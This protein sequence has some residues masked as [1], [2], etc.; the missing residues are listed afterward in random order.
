M[1][2]IIFFELLDSLIA[3]VAHILYLSTLFTDIN[4]LK[5]FSVF[6]RSLAFVFDILL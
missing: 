5:D 3:D 4:N 2:F 6:C 1:V